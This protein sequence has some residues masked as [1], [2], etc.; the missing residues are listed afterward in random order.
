MFDEFR[1]SWLHKELYKSVHKHNWSHAQILEL[2][3]MSVDSHSRFVDSG[4]PV[5]QRKEDF[6][7]TTYGRPYILTPQNA[8]VAQTI[9]DTAYLSF[10]DLL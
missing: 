10:K 3:T 9:I 8:D 1:H 6:N 5:L 2:Y 7:K 4:A